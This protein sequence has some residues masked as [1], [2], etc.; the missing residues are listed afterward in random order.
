MFIYY[1]ELSLWQSLTFVMFTQK[2]YEVKMPYGWLLILLDIYLSFIISYRYMYK[3]Y[4]LV[5][6][7][8]WLRRWIKGSILLFMLPKCIVLSMMIITLA[9]MFCNCSLSYFTDQLLGS[10]SS[11]LLFASLAPCRELFHTLLAWQMILG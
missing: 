1:M 7:K 6:R 9:T 5:C 11:S 4:D 8:H 3:L 10:R 2:Y